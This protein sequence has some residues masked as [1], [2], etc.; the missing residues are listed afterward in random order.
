[1]WTT[2]G[3]ET[4]A[5]DVFGDE[6]DGPAWDM[7][8]TN[9]HYPQE[10]LRATFGVVFSVEALRYSGRVEFVHEQLIG[11]DWEVTDESDESDAFLQ[12]HDEY[13][14]ALHDAVEEMGHWKAFAFSNT[15]W[16]AQEGIHD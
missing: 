9:P 4:L 7:V 15:M 11:G 2:T 5:G 13:G 1:M 6:Q 3:E 16:D 12:D 8:Y 14:P 10:R